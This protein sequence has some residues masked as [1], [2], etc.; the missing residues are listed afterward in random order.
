MG[1]VGG[2]FALLLLNRATHNGRA[3]MFPDEAPAYKNRSKLEVLFGPTI[4]QKI[5]G[6]TILDFGCGQG[7]EA[8]EMAGRGAARVIGLDINGKWLAMARRNADLKGLSGRCAFVTAWHEP[9]DAILS[10]DSFEH[11][12]EPLAV[13]RDMAR[14]LKPDGKVHVSF[15]P[16][17]FHPLG[18]HLYSVFPWSH[19]VF[20]ERALIRWRSLYKTD[21]ARS[22]E[23]SGLNR[24]TIRRFRRTVAASPFRFEDFETVPIRKLRPFHNPLTREFTT[25]VVR[26]TLVK[27]QP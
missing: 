19:L 27:R 4:W 17:W 13:L 26:C 14:L 2:N 10:L 3:S 23:E 12:A 1:V 24:M 25:A 22:I 5:H 8:M 21:G 6:R 18:G 7:N 9:V 15:G 11:F 16:T 20:T